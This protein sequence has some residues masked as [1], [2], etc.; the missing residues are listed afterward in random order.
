MIRRRVT[1]AADK[2]KRQAQ[3]P[4]FKEGLN[5]MEIV[6]WKQLDFHD[7]CSLYIFA[8]GMLYYSDHPTL[9]AEFI[10]LPGIQEYAKKVEEQRNVKPKVEIP[11]RGEPRHLKE[12][13]IT[14]LGRWKF[15]E[16][17]GGVAESA[18]A[19]DSKSEAEKREGS[20]PSAPIDEEENK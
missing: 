2:Q 11:L 18:D 14:Y 6:D 13:E 17:L 1:G 19:P 8:C 4:L 3:D 12:R 15:A 16:E 7:V 10:K 20:N 9:D 5:G